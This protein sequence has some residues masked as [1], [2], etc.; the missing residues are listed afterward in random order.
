MSQRKQP[1]NVVFIPNVR[2]GLGHV[3][4]TLRLARALERAD[5]SLRI[6]YVLS[7]KRLNPFNVAAVESSGYPV[8]VMP[9]A[10]R[11]ERDTLIPA[12]LG[13]ADVVIEDTERRLIAYRRILPRLKLWISLPMVPLWDE[14]FMDWPRLEHADHIL[15]AIP[16]VIPLLEELEPFRHK[17]TVT[18]PIVNPEDAPSRADARRRLG[19]ADD[20]RYITYAPRG[21][22][23]GPEFGRQV[24]A[25]VVGGFLRLRQERPGLRLVL[26]A[27]PD[28]AAVQPP[29]LPPLDQIEGVT[30][31]GVLPPEKVWD[32]LSGA[33]LV[34]LEGSTTLVEAAIARTPVLMVPGTIYETWLEGMWLWEHDLGVVEWIER[35]TPARMAERMRE[36]LAPDAAA[37]RAARLF[38]LI[39]RNGRDI[40]VATVLR[41]IEEK[42]RA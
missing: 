40:A 31:E 4:R 12:A 38:E 14:L 2:G 7:G 21:F 11:A 23:F 42:V 8:H 29:D 28:V 18:G 17:L 41:L 22:P 26:T 13:E 9:N 3:G 34:V 33:D 35:V 15:F 39:G 37:A 5:P 27:V 32:Y 24:L 1:V 6:S 25:G 10:T 20:D 19:L 36:A 16:P 30:V